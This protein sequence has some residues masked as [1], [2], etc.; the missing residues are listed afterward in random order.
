MAALCRAPRGSVPRDAVLPQLILCGFPT[1]RSSPG[2]APH[3]FVPRGPTSGAAPAPSPRA[4]AVPALLPHRGLLPTGC[5]SGPGLLL[6]GI[7]G[8][9]LLQA[10]ATAAPWAS[11]WLHGRSALCGARGLRGDGLL[12]CGPLW[13]AWSCCFVPG[14]PPALTAV[15]AGLLSPISHCSLPAA[16][17]Q[18]I[19]S[20]LNLFSQSTPSIAH[21]SAWPVIEAT[22]AASPPAQHFHVNP[23]QMSPKNTLGKTGIRGCG[24]HLTLCCCVTC[25]IA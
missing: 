21:G 17:V 5:G 10:S 1:G 23:V 3:G 24:L 6:G 19:S 14:A 22:P 13:A 12:L 9:Y 18:H 11:P 7:R 4:A 20:F 8:P 15:P 2:T 25:G 16:V